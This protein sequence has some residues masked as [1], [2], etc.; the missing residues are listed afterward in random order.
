MAKRIKRVA[1]FTLIEV[2]VV[3]ILVSLISGVLFQALERAYR[4]QDR[5]GTELFNL[6][7]GQMTTDWYRQ[8]VQGMFPDY[9]DGNNIFKGSPQ[10]FSG[11][12]TNPLSSDYG[13]PTPVSWKLLPETDQVTA[14]IYTSGKEPT[15]IMHWQGKAARFVYVDDKNTEHESWP[16][17][18]GKFPQLP[19]QIQL[20]T[21]EASEA[22]VLAVTLL[23][24]ALPPLRIK[25]ITGITP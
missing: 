15:P 16:P 24:P 6:Q 11:L 17:P 23:A 1:G 3:L 21:N 25:D 2:L 4:L 22:T 10:A 19:R 7:Q 14:L 12:S 9:P 20:H 18:L 8:T 5:F 13:T